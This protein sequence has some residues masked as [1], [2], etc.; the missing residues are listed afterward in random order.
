MAWARRS[1]LQRG[2]FISFFSDKIS[3]LND[4][5]HDGGS[6]NF[7]PHLQGADMMSQ[8]IAIKASTL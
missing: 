2:P 7:D 5:L 1:L 8:S 3:E 4:Y 6:T